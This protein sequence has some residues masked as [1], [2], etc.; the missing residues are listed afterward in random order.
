MIEAPE[1]VQTEE[2]PAAVIH[3]TIAREEMRNVMGPG[4]SE[5]M[6]AIAA[7][8]IA[9]AGPVF[10]HHLRIDPETFDFELGVPVATPVSAAGRVKPSV[11]PAMRAARTIFHGGYEGLPAAWG[12]FDAWIAAQ[13]HTLAPDLWESYVT[14]PDTNP[15]PNTWRT[16]LTRPVIG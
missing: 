2:Q 10:A 15:D 7:Q 8:H 11:V 4:I 16:E 6:A 5:L 3:F 12:E 13:G 14:T 1:I 9:P